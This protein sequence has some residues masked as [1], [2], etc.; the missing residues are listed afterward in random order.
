MKEI[1]NLFL[2]RKSKK[3]TRQWNPPLFVFWRD[4]LPIFPGPSSV[5]TQTTQDRQSIFDYF[6]QTA[7]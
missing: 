7:G 2:K 1:I 4:M 3:A 5:K 6:N